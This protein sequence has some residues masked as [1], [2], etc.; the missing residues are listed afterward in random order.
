MSKPTEERLGRQ[1]EKPATTPGNV[2]HD[3]AGA[4][5]NA[6]HDVD[7]SDDHPHH[8]PMV[9]YYMVFALL[10]VLLFIT[11]GAWWVD[12][13][14]FPLGRWSTPIALAIA[15]AKAF[16]IVTIFMHVKFSSRLVQIFACTGMFFVCVMF[17]MT[18]NDYLSRPSTSEVQIGI[19][20]P[21]P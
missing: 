21:A 14:V 1:L 19:V 9:Q 16:A 7:H 4:P 18:F 15:F 2:G 5:Q 12:Q 10:M 11:V 8:V 3:T 13:F 20:Q 17:L 6:P